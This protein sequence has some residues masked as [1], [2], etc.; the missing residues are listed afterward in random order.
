[1][2]RVSLI[3]SSLSENNFNIPNYNKGYF[4]QLK[5]FKA[6]FKEDG[7]REKN[8][9]LLFINRKSICGENKETREGTWKIRGICVN[10]ARD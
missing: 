7:K 10:I 2:A 6:S 1:M 8:K 5:E 4:V 9:P 3:N